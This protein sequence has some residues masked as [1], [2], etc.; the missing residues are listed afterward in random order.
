M[1]TL[2]FMIFLTLVLHAQAIQKIDFS[3]TILQ[4]GAFK[5][6][7]VL[8]KLQSKLSSYNLFTKGINGYTKLFVINPTKSQ[9]LQIKKIVPKAFTLSSASK[10]EIFSENTSS[11]KTI[12]EI[13]LNLAPQKDGL[14]TKTIIKTRKK[15]FK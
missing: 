15:F 9:I 7:K 11:K 12:Q 4:V 10:K 5:N 13:K 14:N 8:K 1:K 2:I 3:K 6:Q